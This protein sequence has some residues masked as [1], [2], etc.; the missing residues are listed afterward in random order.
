MEG[1][2]T[3]PHWIGGLREKLGL[4]AIMEHQPQLPPV[5]GAFSQKT[6]LTPLNVPAHAQ[7]Y[8][9]PAA[10]APQPRRRQ[11]HVVSDSVSAYGNKP[12]GKNTHSLC[13]ECDMKPWVRTHYDEF[14]CPV[15]GGA[16]LGTL[17][18]IINKEIMEHNIDVDNDDVFV[19]WMELET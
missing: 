13:L 14:H 4:G 18:N 3:H 8:V 11:A 5:T 17:A 2:L 7:L 15:K 1:K 10:A 6:V 16:T 19:W 12:K 9:A